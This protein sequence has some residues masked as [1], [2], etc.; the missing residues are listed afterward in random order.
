[1]REGGDKRRPISLE[2]LF[3]VLA[4]PLVLLYLVLLLVVVLP[5]F[6]LYSLLLYTMVSI[7]WL[8]RGKDVLFVYSNSPHWKEYIESNI[9]PRLRDRAI[10]M[11]WSERRRWSEFS[12]ATACFRHFS[13]A[14]EFNPLAVVFRPLRRAKIFRFFEAFRLLKHGAPSL[15]HQT[16]SDLFEYLAAKRNRKP[17]SGG[18]GKPGT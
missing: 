1:M 12:L 9:V 14:R 7:R 8:A 2:S 4:I 16:E 18:I 5:L 17:R 3:V 6:L 11:N 15:L 13:G 10:V